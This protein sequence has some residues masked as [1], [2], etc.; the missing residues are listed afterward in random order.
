MGRMVEK[1]GLDLFPN[2][3]LE[4]FFRE[5]RVKILKYLVARYGLNQ[6]NAEDCFQEG[7]FAVWKNV[8]E[9][10][11]T[12]ENL[13]CSLSTYLTR[14]CCNHATHLLNVKSSS[15]AF[16]DIEYHI[17]EDGEVVGA[18]QAEDVSEE[19]EQTKNELVEVLEEVMDDLPE[20]YRQILW[21]H[22][23]DKL[24]ME[25]MA[26]KFGYSNANT[27]KTI[28]NRCLNALKEKMLARVKNM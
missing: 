22:Y 21:A 19:D 27:M 24:S 6:E 1:R 17:D 20:S 25:E 3:D 10:K 8:K 28:K 23:R 9:G 26:I 12:K 16:E 18:D 7:S 4:K 2:G 15:L 5:E 13:N 11:L 14:C